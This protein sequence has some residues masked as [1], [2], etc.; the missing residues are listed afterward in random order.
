MTLAK[1]SSS[2]EEVFLNFLIFRKRGT[3]GHY[4][5]LT[6]EMS[7]SDRESFFKSVTLLY[8]KNTIP[9]VGPWKNQKNVFWCFQRVW[10]VT[11]RNAG[12][13]GK[14]E[15]GGASPPPFPGAKSFFHVKSE[16]IKSLQV[17]NIWDLSLFIERGI[18]DKK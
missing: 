5:T 1:W 4:H 17:K 10:K 3:K 8:I 16:T 13:W 12:P 2:D 14:E 15:R 18:S 11:G 6:Q 7:K 9:F